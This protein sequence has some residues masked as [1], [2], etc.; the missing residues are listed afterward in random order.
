MVTRT[1]Y[2]PIDVAFTN[3]VL[4]KWLQDDTKKKYMTD[5]KATQAILQR[6]DIEL[7]GVTF[8]LLLASYIVNPAISSDDVQALA[9]EFGYSEVQS[10]EAIYGKGAKWTRPEES[11]LADHVARK[12]LAVWH[13]QPVLEEKLK[14]NEQ[15]ELYK[16]LE[17]PL[18]SILGKM[19]S[20]GITVHVDTL[21]QMGD[22][23]AKKLDV[24]EATIYEFAGEKFNINSP[25]QLGVILF[26][27]LGL[28]AIKK[29]KTGYSTAADV[30]EKLQY[31]HEIVKH[32]LDYRQL[33][34]LKSTY[35]EGLIKDVHVMIQKCIH[36]INKH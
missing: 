20:Q 17:L 31:E 36:V 12:A 9:K 1:L 26:E 25:K 29:T 32:I 10:N 11:V 34:K 23:L 28:Q 33:A 30:L 13:L 27:K 22:D 24:I 7:R 3:E 14:E 5:S 6:M 15:F 18:A 16:N 21:E 8:D 19:E 4:K 2:L 35:I